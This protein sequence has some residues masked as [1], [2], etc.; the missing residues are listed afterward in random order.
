MIAY[1]DASVVLRL[2]LR[3]RRRL[4]DWKHV[5]TAVAARSRRWSVSARSTA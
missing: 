3:E 1:L 5:E 2:V 4:A